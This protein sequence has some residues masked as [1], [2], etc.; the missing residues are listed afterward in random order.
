MGR[1]PPGPTGWPPGAK[2]RLVA[3]TSNLKPQ[4]L[5]VYGLENTASLGGCGNAGTPLNVA[6]LGLGGEACSVS[7]MLGTHVVLPSLTSSFRPRMAECP[8]HVFPSPLMAEGPS[9]CCSP[10]TWPGRV[11]VYVICALGLAGW[12]AHVIHL[13]LGTRTHRVFFVLRLRPSRD[14]TTRTPARS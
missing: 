13:C 5:P 3:E 4:T 2:R 11:A 10:H 1:I 14:A 9:F 12:A 7:C 8:S 6:P